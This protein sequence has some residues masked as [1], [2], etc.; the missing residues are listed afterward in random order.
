MSWYGMSPAFLEAAPLDH[1]LRNVEAICILLH[2]PHLIA[3]AVR[4]SPH[5]LRVSLKVSN[6]ISVGDLMALYARPERY[7]H[8]VTARLPKR[9]TQVRCLPPCD[10]AMFWFMKRRALLP[11]LQS[12]HAACRMPCAFPPLTCAI[13]SCFTWLETT[14]VSIICKYTLMHV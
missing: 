2:V 3:V 9:V 11:V 6:H 7:V 5:R 13:T 1:C 10:D 4:P 8:L 14:D 12:P